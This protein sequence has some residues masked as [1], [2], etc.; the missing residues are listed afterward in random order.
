MTPRNGLQ[1]ALLLPLAAVLFSGSRAGAQASDRLPRDF[2][3]AQVETL[4]NHHPQWAVGANDSGAV[5]AELPLSTITLALA[6]S[7]Q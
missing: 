7:S 5:P 3:S 4:A 1:L 2:D 6:R